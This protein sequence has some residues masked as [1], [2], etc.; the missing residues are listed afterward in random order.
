[1]G[2]TLHQQIE[3]D[4]VRQV[5]QMPFSKASSHAYAGRRQVK[6][7]TGAMHDV[8]CRDVKSCLLLAGDALFC[9]LLL[10]LRWCNSDRRRETSLSSS[11]STRGIRLARCR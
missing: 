6:S 4:A 3:F 1:M 8:S 11:I 5:T 10:D 2:H 9:L 7:L